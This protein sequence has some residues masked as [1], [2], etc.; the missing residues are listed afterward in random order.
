MDH[1]ENA[2]SNFL[3]SLRIFLREFQDQEHVMHLSGK[4]CNSVVCCS[5]NSKLGI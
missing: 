5:T 4:Y 1:D 2:P 3:G